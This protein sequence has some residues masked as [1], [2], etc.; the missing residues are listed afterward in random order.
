MR[1]MSNFHLYSSCSFGGK[2]FSFS[3]FPQFLD[4]QRLFVVNNP[5][6]RILARKTYFF[7][8]AESYC[9]QSDLILQQNFVGSLVVLMQRFHPCQGAN[10]MCLCFYCLHDLGNLFFPLSFCICKKYFLFSILYAIPVLRQLT[11][12]EVVG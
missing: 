8:D 7:V 12:L 5:S 2:D 1:S 6:L 9:I 11:K 3:P 10:S 4:V